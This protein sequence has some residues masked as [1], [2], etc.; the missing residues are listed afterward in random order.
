[1]SERLLVDAVAARLVARRRGRQVDHSGRDDLILVHPRSFDR[2][3]PAAGLRSLG[4]AVEVG[5]GIV[6]IRIQVERPSV[7]ERELDE[8]RHGGDHLRSEVAS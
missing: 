7:G 1:M 8:P 4:L 3:D 5:D 2:L 6:L